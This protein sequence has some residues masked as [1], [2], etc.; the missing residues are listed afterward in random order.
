M[1]STLTN[2]QIAAAFEELADLYELSGAIQYRVIAYRNAAHSVRESAV[3]VAPL[4]AEDRATDLPGIGPTLQDKI[5]ALAQTGDIPAAVKLREQ[6]PT[7]LIEIMHLPGFGPKRARRLYDE[8]AIDSLE[9]LRAACEAHEVRKLR[10]FGPKVETRLLEVLSTDGA[11]RPQPRILLSRATKV[12][13]QFVLALSS[14][15][16]VQR[17][18]IAGSIRRRT[19]SVKDVDIVVSAAD[20]QLVLSVVSELDL[21]ESVHSEGKAGARVVTHSGLRIELRVVDDDQFGNALQH[22]TG[23]QRHNVEL[24]ELAVTRGLHLSEYGILDDATGETQR[25]GD[26]ADVYRRLGLDWI[27]PELR[28][29]RGEIAAAAQGTLPKLITIADIRGDLHCH[30]TRS[31]GRSSA[32]EMATSA[33]DRGYEYIA[34][35]DHSATHGFGNDVSPDELRRAIEETRALDEELDGIKVLIGTETNILPDGSLDY[36]DDLLAELDWVV[37]SVHT[38]FGMSR[39]DM[40]AR[41]ITAIEHPLVDVIG[42]PTGRKIETREPYDVDVERLIVA[43]RDSAT[44][45]EINSAPD[46]RDLNEFYA[47]AAAEAGV[48]IVIDSDAHSTRT[49]GIIEYGI[50]TAR[51]AWLTAEQVANTRTWP[52]LVKLRKRGRRGR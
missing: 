6:F 41:M 51:R 29:G 8:L 10:G 16:E 13:E 33:R 9:K 40:T 35:T 7:G 14:Q 2:S 39:E 18:E 24:R 1:S 27:E 21:V 20:P 38:S 3:A 15:V 17:I 11:Q 19:D 47:R 34:L 52:E 22:L 37:A 26:E 42:H 46:R 28:E 44:M 4:A 50:A 45:L 36:D 49:Q 23:S 48:F 5:N 32:L 12:A 31:D 30:T 43:A 25:C